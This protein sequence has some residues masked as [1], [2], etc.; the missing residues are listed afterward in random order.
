MVVAVPLAPIVQGDDEQV[1]SL[2]R[3]EGVT[4][5][6]P[7]GKR[8]TQRPGQSVQHGRCHEELLNRWRLMAQHF[9]DQVVD[10]VA[11]IAGEPGD[12]A[13][14]VRAPLKGQSSQL[15]RGDPSLRPRFQGGHVRHGEVESGDLVEVRRGL[16]GREAQVGCP[17]LH[18]LTA[19]PPTRQG[20]L[21]VGA[22]AEHDVHG[23]R[24]VLDEERHA[25]ADLRTVHQV[26]VV[27]DQPHLAR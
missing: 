19:H 15:Q 23:R 14:H 16:V 9:L 12:E 10:D 18:Q 25:L 6:V 7:A 8:I 24:Q 13:A 3:N 20:Q 11:V 17:D 1:R 5:V 2:E 22:C 21:R 26:V 27:Q 4:S